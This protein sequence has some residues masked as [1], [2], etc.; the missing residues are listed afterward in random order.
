MIAKSSLIGV[1]SEFGKK[2]STFNLLTHTLNAQLATTRK[3]TYS[4][5]PSRRGMGIIITRGA[6]KDNFFFI[7]VKSANFLPEHQL[8][9]NGTG[10]IMMR[11]WINQRQE[12]PIKSWQLL[13]SSEIHFAESAC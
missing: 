5:L 11:T 9:L 2:S 1:A 7:M 4:Q 3:N 12:P 8:L 6:N 10:V 13:S